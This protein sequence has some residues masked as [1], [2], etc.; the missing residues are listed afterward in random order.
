VA[1]GVAR[2]EQYNGSLGAGRGPLA[3]F[4]SSLLVAAMVGLS[5]LLPLALLWWALPTVSR[6]GRL[7]VDSLARGGIGGVFG[8]LL[9]VAGWALVAAPI[10]AAQHWPWALLAALGLLAAW[11]VR[12]G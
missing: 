7:V 8:Y 3:G 1:E 12:R 9:G 10:L 2:N 4:A 5:F 11:V 6:D